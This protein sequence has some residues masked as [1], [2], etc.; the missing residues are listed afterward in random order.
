M[1]KQDI[2][3]GVLTRGFAMPA[4]GCCK[5]ANIRFATDNGDIAQ[6]QLMCICMCR[7]VHQPGTILE[8]QEDKKGTFWKGMVQYSHHD[9]A[10]DVMQTVKAWHEH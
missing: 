2:T 1:L 7:H 8:L 4:V 9:L 10:C 6:R 3:I 5:P